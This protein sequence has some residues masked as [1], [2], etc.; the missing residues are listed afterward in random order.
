MFELTGK[1]NT[2]KVYATFINDACISQILDMCNQEW[3]SGTDIAIMPDCHAGRGATIGTTILLKDKVSPSLVGVDIS[4][5]MLVVRIPEELDVD[6]IK[7]DEFINSNIPSGFDIHT[8]VQIPSYQCKF[9]EKLR[10]FDQISDFEYIKKSLGTLGGG[11]HFIEINISS[12]GDKFLVVHSGSRNLGKQIAEIYQ[13]TANRNCNIKPLNKKRKDLIEQ[14]KTEGKEKMIQKSLEQLK[15]EQQPS[16]PYH[17]CYLEGKDFEDYIHDCQIC[18]QYASLNRRIIALKILE[19]I[20]QENGYGNSA[21][22]LDEIGENTYEFGFENSSADIRSYGF[23]SIHNYIGKDNIL[24]KG[25]ISAGKG[26][27]V[28]IPIN[29][30]DG[31]IIGTGKGNP[32][33]NCSGPHGAGRVLSR[34]EAKEK[35]SL[36]EFHDVMKDVYSTSVCQS[37]LDESPMAYKNADDIISNIEDSIEI[38][39]IIKPIY[40]YKSH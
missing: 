26:E 29:M 3:L 30:K 39:E 33:Y 9:I 16:I 35:I 32:K 18:N 5:G 7:I 15:A 1:Y 20:V 38:K 36:D 27:Q 4:C 19:F 28:I 2:A 23:Q 34:S 21:V 14:L 12:N 22:W 40:N 8:E 10:C 37:T 25:A 6:V 31:S 17:L 13:D 11:N 24:R